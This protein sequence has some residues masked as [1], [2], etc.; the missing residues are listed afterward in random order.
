VVN[1]DIEFP[2]AESD[3]ARMYVATPYTSAISLM[4][5]ANLRRPAE[6]MP[7]RNAAQRQIRYKQAPTLV[8]LRGSSAGDWKAANRRADTLT[9][10]S[11]FDAEDG[12]NNFQ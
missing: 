3:R 6:Q 9:S 12:V 4:A 7:A 11:D 8:D 2:G 1:F 10:G 5:A